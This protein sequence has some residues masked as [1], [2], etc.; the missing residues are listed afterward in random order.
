MVLKINYLL[1][2]TSLKYVLLNSANY[3]KHYKHKLRYCNVQTLCLCL[4]ITLLKS[5]KYCNYVIRINFLLLETSSDIL[6]EVVRS[7]IHK[8]KTTIS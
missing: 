4:E 1:Q 3:K 5:L 7:I 8:N 6:L 2:E